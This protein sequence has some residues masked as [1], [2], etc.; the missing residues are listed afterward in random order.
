[1]GIWFMHDNHTFTRLDTLEVETAMARLEALVAAQGGTGFVGT[2]GDTPD[3]V[4]AWRKGEPW[5]EKV[6]ALLTTE[7]T[8]HATGTDATP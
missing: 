3:T 6:L 4:I 2:K 7:R 5:R 1:M 8:Q